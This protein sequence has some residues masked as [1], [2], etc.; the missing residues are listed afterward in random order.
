[1][2]T[3][4]RNV[5]QGNLNTS[6]ALNPT[7]FPTYRDDYRY[8]STQSGTVR[9]NL[10]SSQFDTFLQVLD[11]RTGEVLAVNDDF[12]P[13]SNSQI[14]LTIQPGS[15]FVV[16]VTSYQAYGVG[17]YSLTITTTDPPAGSGIGEGGLQ[18]GGGYSPVYGYGLVD[19]AAAIARSI[20]SI[21]PPS[22]QFNFG[23]LDWSNDIVNAPDGWARNYT[24][25]GITV[26]VIDTGVDYTHPDLDQNIWRNYGEV[27]GNGLDDDGNGYV[28]DFIGWD[29]VDQDNNPMDGKEHGTHVAGT[30]AAEN[31]GV[32]IRGVAYNARIMPIRVLGPN[33]GTNSNIAAG[34]RYAVDNGAQVI[35]MSLGGGGFSQEIADAVEYATLRNSMVVIAA[36][37]EGEPQPANP[38]ALAT[39]WGLVVGA[40][41]RNLNMADFSNLAGPSP[42]MA[43]V[44]APGVEITSTVPGGGYTNLDGTSMAAP[45]V[46]GVVAQMLSANPNLT[47]TQIRQILLETALS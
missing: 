34:I 31:N 41:D 1:M 32:G 3:N 11:T 37:N 35:N 25:Q 20:R 14:S 24:G 30:I 21:A 8:T 22:D 42:A 28:D 23:G 15:D 40:I 4:S 9:F 39:R 7:R 2:A 19:A 43:Y 26:A 6:D 47:P 13:G 44:V 36:G 38:G 18:R 12:G 45:H 5:F 16:R 17:D 29:F 10:D 46:A 27:P 33:G